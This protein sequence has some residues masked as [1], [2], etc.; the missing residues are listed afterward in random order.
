MEPNCIYCSEALYQ[1]AIFCH[2]CGSQQKCKSCETPIVKKAKH[3]IGCGI[4]LST[5]AE[6]SN[7]AVNTIKFNQTKDSRSYEVAFT[8]S[9]GV[10][11]VD[12][13]RN[14]TDNEPF[15]QL[16]GSK[17]VKQENNIDSQQE[18]TELLTE[19]VEVVTLEPIQKSGHE[20]PQIP[21]L[22][23]VENTLDCSE[24]HWILIYAFYI[25][26]NGGNTFGRN[27]L[28]KA[29]KEKRE[30]PTRMSNFAVNWKSL[31]KLR[32]VKTI[33]DG[34]FKLTTDG[35]KTI[36]DLV[37]GKIKAKVSKTAPT[38][39]ST[40][41]NKSEKESSGG[42]R[43]AKT[44]AKSVQTEDF[45]LYKTAKKTSLAD[46]FK[47]KKVDDNTA[48]RILAI[49]YYIKNICKLT[50]FS[51]GNVEFAYKVLNLNK[52]PLHLHQTILNTKLRKLWFDQD[53]STGKWKLTRPG[54]VFFEENF[55]QKG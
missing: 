44:P 2:N 48:H 7:N 43:G 18:I 31:F 33:K 34:E 52:R 49:A 19:E 36:S 47:E 32:L 27:D 37:Q 28:H 17:T 5:A 46:F 14:M 6:T 26:N 21:H 42:K 3:C 13:I 25:S 29:Y 51:E 22:N 39:R 35:V 50:S 11:V 16:Q 54:E 41:N 24:P 1:N 45:D 23:D 38:K 53:E 9:V 4:A 20:N 55:G 8:D 15:L 12:V 40:K 10:G 30:T